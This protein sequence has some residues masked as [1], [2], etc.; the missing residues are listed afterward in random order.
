MCNFL[1]WPA[2]SV[3]VS[4]PCD[5]RFKVGHLAKGQPLVTGVTPIVIQGCHMKGDRLQATLQVYRREPGTSPVLC[6]PGEEVK[7]IRVVPTIIL[8]RCTRGCCP[9]VADVS[10]QPDVRRTQRLNTL[11][12]ATDGSTCRSKQSPKM[13]C[14]QQLTC[15][16]GTEESHQWQH[17]TKERARGIV[18]AH[19][20]IHT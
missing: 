1:C 5:N 9:S 17:A 14:G 11:V 20:H 13:S 16:A 4:R 10:E 18:P 12:R 2:S 15:I 3:V 7:P 19:A 8:P 6:G